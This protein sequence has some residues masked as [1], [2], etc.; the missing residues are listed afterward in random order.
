M[1]GTTGK[2][3]GNSN[4]SAPEVTKDEL[5]RQLAEIEAAEQAAEAEARTEAL[6]GLSDGVTVAAQAFG[7]AVA[8]GDLQ[9]ILTAAEALQGAASGARKAVR[10]FMPRTRSGGAGTGGPRQVFAVPL[11][12]AIEADMEARDTED[13]LTA[14]SV[15]RSIG[16][17]GGA[18][19]SAWTKGK[20]MAV[21]Q[22]GTG[23]DRFRLTRL[24]SAETVD[25]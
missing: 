7:E 3:K 1:S 24:I 23:P 25:A 6:Q 2:G 20:V 21:T 14:S 16:R 13:G 12:E 22:V 4:G 15:G 8:G 9:N 18:V 5:L 19:T 10:E 11:R 17:S